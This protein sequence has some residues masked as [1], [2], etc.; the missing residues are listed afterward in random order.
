MAV[1]AVGLLD[2]VEH[3]AIPGQ[4]RTAVVDAVVVHQDVEIVPQRPGELGLGIHQVHDPQV[5]CEPADMRLE[6]RAR[7]TAALG[8]RPQG[9]EAAA[10]AGRRRTNRRRRHQR[11]TGGAGLAAPLR[12]RG[13]RRRRRRHRTGGRTRPAEQRTEIQ[14]LGR[15]RGGEGRRHGHPAEELR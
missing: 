12:R 9:G 8:L 15:P 5:G 1:D 13:Y 11:V 6:G 3:R 7:H 10:E 4:D 2:C 14:T